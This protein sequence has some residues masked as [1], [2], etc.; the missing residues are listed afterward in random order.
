[1]NPREEST[2]VPDHKRK[3]KRA[4]IPEK[5]PH[6]NVIYDLSAAEKVCPQ[7]GTA[8]RHFGNETS[9]QLDYI[10]AQMSVF[11]HIRQKYNCPCCNDYMV[12]ANT[13]PA[14]Y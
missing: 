14:A 2:N 13:P 9:E 8:L 5:L 12:T 6:T 3:K 7:D 4:S 1:L 11:K 10:P